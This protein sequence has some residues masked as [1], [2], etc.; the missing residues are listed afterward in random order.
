MCGIAGIFLKGSQT[1]NLKGSIKSM[2]RAIKHRGPDGEGYL[3]GRTGDYQPFFG[4]N[5]HFKQTF[6]FIPKAA[7]EEANEGYAL[8]LS[9]VRLSILD[10][11]DSGHQPMCDLHENYWITYNGEIYNYLELKEELRLLGV[12]FFGNS[13]TEVI[14]NAFK[15]WGSKCVEK[16]NGMW[17]F[18]L[19]DKTS[20]TVFASRDRLGVKPFYYINNTDFFAFASEQKAFV[21]ANLVE[22]KSSL[23]HQFDYLIN[24]S[25]EQESANFFEGIIELLPGHNLH[26]NLSTHHLHTEQYYILNKKV[27]LE[28][29]YLSDQ[30]LIKKIQ[31]TLFNA[32]KLRLR[33]DVEVGTCLSGGIDS[34]AISVIMQRFMQQ[35]LN[36]FTAQ[37]KNTSIDESK[38]ARLVTE[39]L[40]AKHY[41]VEPTITEFENEVKALVYSQDVPIWS[42]ST[43]AQFK[44][45]ELAKQ[46]QIKVVLDGQGADELFAG[47][48]HHFVAQWLQLLNEN[49]WSS[50]NSALRASRKS[51]DSPYLFFIKDMIKSK[52]TLNGDSLAKFFKQDFLKTS[53]ID[54]LTLFK[55]VNSQL[56]HDIEIKRLKSFLKCEDRCGMWHGVESRTPFSDDIHLIELLFS[57]DGKRKIKNG[58]SKYFLREAV[59]DL[60]PE[61]IYKRYDKK[62]FETPQGAWIKQLFPSMI[63]RIKAADFDFLNTNFEKNININK[64]IDEKL[65]FKLYVLSVWKKVFVE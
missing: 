56:I 25:L 11:T 35:P 40:N 8:A 21:K 36:C 38:Y 19:I 30:Q 52:Q 1:I 54:K 55:N 23:N 47:Y 4:V 29:D 14:I 49:K 57:F 59:K 41:F 34:S 61:P 43:F 53:A 65:I 44:V 48:H 60:L 20:N 32:V 62:G 46:Q 33:S 63:E 17:S 16:F 18:V 37:F 28:N 58:A 3:L 39:Q 31:E 10:L 9:H 45:M 13:D 12:K 24:T 64:G 15:T 2:T 42:T 26:Y 5:Q 27:N 6:N 50:L 22:A 51:I 7:I